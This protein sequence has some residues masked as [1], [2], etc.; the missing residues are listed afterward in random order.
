MKNF[1]L[2]TLLFVYT[3]MVYSR[4]VKLQLIIEENNYP[5]N[6]SQ[7]IVIET[8]HNLRWQRP[9]YL[10]EG[11]NW[12]Q[13]IKD[14]KAT[15]H[16]DIITKDGSTQNSYMVSDSNT[17]LVFLLTPKQE[18]YHSYIASQNTMQFERLVIGSIKIQK[19]IERYAKY[20]NSIINY[21]F[22]K[23][24]LENPKLIEFKADTIGKKIIPQPIATKYVNPHTPPKLGLW[25]LFG[26]A[27]LIFLFLIFYKFS[28]NSPMQIVI[29]S[30][31]LAFSAMLLVGLIDSIT[32]AYGLAKIFDTVPSNLLIVVSTI[33]VALVIGFLP[34]VRQ[35]STLDTFFKVLFYLGFMLCI[36]LDFLTSY[37]GISDFF[38]GTEFAGRT[39]QQKIIIFILTPFFPIIFVG[40]AHY[41]SRNQNP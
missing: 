30:K 15:I 26:G 16:K 13:L 27:V 10:A 5:P 33:A 19:L 32:T 9:I 40:L 20:E 6:S 11:F 23:P 28:N 39:F 17:Y 29:N 35:S 36:S 31:T 18:L 12:D 14:M 7:V 2:T 37:I 3:S 34:A 24:Q 25:S 4:D 1:L 22:V 8:V 38:G 41:V 21:F